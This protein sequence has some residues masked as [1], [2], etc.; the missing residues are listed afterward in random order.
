MT[1]STQHRHRA[2]QQAQRPDSAAVGVNSTRRH[3]HLRFTFATEAADGFAQ[4]DIRWTLPALLRQRVKGW[5]Q[6]AGGAFHQVQIEILMRAVAA[7]I[8]QTRFRTQTG[9]VNQTRAGGMRQ[10]ADA[11]FCV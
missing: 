7:T 9:F 5:L 1:L 8:D 6:A 2:D 3:H 11:A 10:P 4:G